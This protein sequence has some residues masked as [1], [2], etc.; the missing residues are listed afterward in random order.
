MSQKAFEDAEIENFL[1]AELS[2][3]DDAEK[4]QNYLEKLTGARTV[5]NVLFPIQHTLLARQKS[6]SIHVL[7]LLKVPRVFIRGEFVGGGTEVQQ[8][9][10]EGKLAEM[11]NNK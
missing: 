8:L 4:I 1:V 3:R 6:L 2:G 11:C 7:I 10:K 5:C 9:Q